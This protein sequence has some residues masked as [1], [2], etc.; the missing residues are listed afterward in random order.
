[1]TPHNTMPDDTP[2]ASTADIDSFIARWADADGSERANYQ[3]FLTELVELYEELGFEVQLREIDPETL[4]ETCS[5]CYLAQPERFR[6]I[7]TRRRTADDSSDK[8]GP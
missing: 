1:M 7:Y 5:E 6:T 4:G 8:G 2:I 3:L